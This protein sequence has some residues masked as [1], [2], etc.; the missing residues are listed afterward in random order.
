MFIKQITNGII[1]R[2]NE[3]EDNTNNISNSNPTLPNVNNSQ[4]IKTIQSKSSKGVLSFV[5][6]NN[7][8]GENVLDL[9]L[10]KTQQKNK[11]NKTHSRIFV[12]SLNLRKRPIFDKLIQ[13][14][15][16]IENEN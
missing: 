13:R 2:I 7:I 4:P 14:Q 9:N 6:S 5:I 8:I 1:N 10:P 3:E 16:Q 12:S 11:E 15:S